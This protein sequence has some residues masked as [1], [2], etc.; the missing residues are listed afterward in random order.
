MK[1]L[2]K[3]EHPIRKLRLDKRISQLKLALML[4]ISQSKLSQYET[5][6]IHTPKYIITEIARI[7]KINKDKLIKE[8]DDFYSRKKEKLMKKYRY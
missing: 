3:E 1:K 8:S 6:A 7:F 4:N 2:N 5:S